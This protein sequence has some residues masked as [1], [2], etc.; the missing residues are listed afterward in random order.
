MNR[1]LVKNAMILTMGMKNVIENGYVYIEDNIIKEVNEGEYTG[2]LNGVYVINAKGGILMPGFVNA[3]THIP[4]TLLR[5][6][7]DGLPLMKWLKEKIWPFENK[8]TQEDVEIG[9]YLGLI[10]MIRSGTTSFIDMYFH[11]INIADV[12]ERVKVRGF[13]A[14]TIIG[15]K[16]DEQFKYVE[17]MYNKFKDSDYVKVL[18]GPHSPYTLEKEVLKQVGEYARYRKMPIH[19]HLSET[20]DE[21]EI[22]KEKYNMTPIE[23]CDSLGLFDKTKTIAAHCVHLYENDYEILKI[24]DITAAHNPQSNMKLASGIAPITKMIDYKINVALGTDGTSSNN[25]LDMFDEMRS[26]SLLQ[27]LNNMDATALSSF[28]TIKMA[29]I[30]GY[31]GLGV[32]NEIGKIEE[33]Y[34]ADMIIVDTNKAHLIPIH[35]VYSNIVFSANG[36]DVK[37]VIV[38]GNIIMENY[39]LKTIDEEY[40]LFEAKRRVKDILSR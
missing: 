1:V 21:I 27:K 8:L 39:E 17:D 34:K 32:D 7:G 25:N 10:E 15:E 9:T 22:I 24:K 31:I 23:L 12:V 5:G 13:L 38:D 30:N 20:L 6:H 11:E 18:I 33:N 19:I 14:H 37:T 35:D 4:M 3:H 2:D 26:A 16:N 28:N 40:Y 29:T 36:N